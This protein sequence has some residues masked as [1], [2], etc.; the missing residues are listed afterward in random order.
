M[1]S[2]MQSGARNTKQ[3]AQLRWRIML[4]DHSHN[5]QTAIEIKK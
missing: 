1:Q 3:L 2:A 4:L 5:P